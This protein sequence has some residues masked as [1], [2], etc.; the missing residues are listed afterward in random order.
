MKDFKINF[1]LEKWHYYLLGLVLINFGIG[2]FT[3]Y[4]LNQ[5][6]TLIL[7]TIL[8]LTGVL[9]FFKTLKPFKL[10]TA[11]FSFYLISA[12]LTGLFFLFGGIFLAILSSVVLYPIYPK[13]TEY[14][15]ETIRIY[16]RFQGFMSR[17]CSYEVVEPKLYFFEKHLGYIN[18]EKPIDAAK[19]VFTLKD[20]TIIYKYELENYESDNRTKEIRDTTVVLNFE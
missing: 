12:A 18:I 6:L 7:K 5:N 8:Y 20:N 11:Y 9:L 13:Q 10:V 19:D 3:S 15:T 14:K 2:V 16:D 1:K 4:R 17:C